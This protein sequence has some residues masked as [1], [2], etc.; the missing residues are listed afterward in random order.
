MLP[1]P[2]WPWDLEST[3]P[4]LLLPLDPLLTPLAIL[5]SLAGG[6]FPHLEIFRLARFLNPAM[7]CMAAVLPLYW[8][9]LYKRLKG[10]TV[11]I[12]LNLVGQTY[13]ISMGYSFGVLILVYIGGRSLCVGWCFAKR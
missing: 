1:S 11:V 10:W 3:I 5:W 13:R 8:R 4:R 2:F 9:S 6:W 7:A 12:G